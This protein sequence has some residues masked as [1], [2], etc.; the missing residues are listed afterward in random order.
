MDAKLLL[1]ADVHV[2]MRDPER[3]VVTLRDITSRLR[4]AHDLDLAQERF[5]LAFHGA[6]TGMA[7]SNADS[8]LLDRRQRIAGHDARLHPCRTARQGGAVDHSS[9]RLGS[10]A[11]RRPPTRTTWSSATSAS[12]KSVMWASNT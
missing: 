6:P 8:G 9:R 4:E 2:P 5:R 7:L 11:R 3:V 1:E 10:A 12:D